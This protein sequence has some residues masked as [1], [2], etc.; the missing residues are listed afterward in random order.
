MRSLIEHAPRCQRRRPPILRAAWDAAP[1]V[2]CP[3]CGR[4]APADDQRTERRTTP[5]KPT[6]A[7]AAGSGSHKRSENVHI[8]H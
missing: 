6:Q 2:W 5:S 1:E 8:I 7:Q 3:E 4:S